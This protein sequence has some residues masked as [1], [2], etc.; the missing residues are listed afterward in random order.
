L[1]HGALEADCADLDHRRM[2]RDRLAER[3][4]VEQGFTL[5]EVLVVIILVGILA[6][7]ALAVFLTQLDKG[8]DSGA[9]S[10]VTNL[11]RLVQVCNAGRPDPEDF[12]TCSTQA[13]LGERSIPIDPAAPGLAAGDCGDG[14][15]G[16]VQAGSARVA[17]A[18]RRCFVVVGASKSGNKFWY[19]KHDDGSVVRDCTTRGVNGC[20]SDGTWAG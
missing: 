17:L 14:D 6:S 3:L 18:G 16:S 9:K 10:N 20:P 1:N 4:S 15:P 19:V 7:I 11:A 2:M 5:V 8:R 12:R 13:D